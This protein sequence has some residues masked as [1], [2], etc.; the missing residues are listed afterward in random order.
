VAQESADLLLIA[1]VNTGK[2]K[3]WVNEYDVGLV[4]DD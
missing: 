3:Q 4:L 1:Y 2:G